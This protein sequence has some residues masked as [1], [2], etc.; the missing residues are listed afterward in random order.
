VPEFPRLGFNCPSCFTVLFIKDPGAYDG[1]AAP[2]P[3][4][5]VAIM[6]PRVAPLSPFILVAEAAPAQREL[7]PVPRTSRWK[8]FKQPDFAA[9]ELCSA[10]QVA[11]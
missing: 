2:C 9:S 10:D 7:P 1:R 6:P 8:P 4:C 3:Y 11:G 5:R